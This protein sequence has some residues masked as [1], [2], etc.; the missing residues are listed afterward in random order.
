MP[1]AARR[2]TLEGALT[3]CSRPLQRFFCIVVHLAAL[4]PRLCLFTQ[5]MIVYQIYAIEL[6]RPEFKHHND[7]YATKCGVLGHDK[8]SFS[9]ASAELEDSSA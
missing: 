9:R 3:R 6:S 2:S 5:T 8:L 1:V 7:R 4:K